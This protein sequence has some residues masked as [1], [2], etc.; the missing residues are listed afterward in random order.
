VR[1]LAEGRPNHRAL[2]RWRTGLLGRFPAPPETPSGVPRAFHDEKPPIDLFPVG[3]PETLLAWR[4]AIARTAIEI[5][6]DALRSRPAALSHVRVAAAVVW[7]NA[8]HSRV[9]Y[10]FDPDYF[11]G[12]EDRNTDHQ[13]WTPLGAERSLLREL[14]VSEPLLRERGYH[15]RIVEDP[16]DPQSP[17]SEAE[18]WMLG[19]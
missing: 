4:M 6:A 9:T 17:V 7:P 5:A 10:F 18:I 13:R 11:A 19:H 14:G 3:S 8:E 12:F 2:R 16:G 1:R 15:E